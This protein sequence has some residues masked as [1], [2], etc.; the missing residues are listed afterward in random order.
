MTSN[1][2][3][4][5]APPGLP[6]LEVTR[7]FDASPD[8]VFRAWTDPELVARWLG[9]RRHEM[10]IDDWDA[11]T[12]GRYSYIH[13]TTEGTEHRFRGVFHTVAAPELI[14]AD[15]RVRRRTGRGQPRVGALRGPGRSHPRPAARR[16]LVRRGS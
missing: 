10:I 11:R 16:V 14:I 9:P 8:L 7:E 13:R 12:G 1:P 6:V 5:D 15:L 4:I 2:T 3:T